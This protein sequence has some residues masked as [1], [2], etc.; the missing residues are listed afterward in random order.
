MRPALRALAAL[1]TATLIALGTIAGPVAAATTTLVSD[2]QA[3]DAAPSTAKIVIIV[4]PTHG[5]TSSFRSDADAAYVEALTW[6]SNVTKIYSPNALWTTVKAAVAGANIVVYLGHGNGWPS[7]YTYDPNYTTKDGF[8]LNDPNNRRDDVVK[9]YGE[10][11]IDDLALAPGAVIILNHSCYSSGSSEPGNPEPTLSVAKQ[12]VDNFGSAF[13]KAGAAA[14]IAA[15]KGSAAN[16]IH[17]LFTQPGTVFDAWRGTSGYK[18]HE[19][20]YPSVRR[21]GNTFILDPDTAGGGGYNHSI[22]GNPQALTSN[23]VGQMATDGDPDSIQVP[24]AAEAA[25]GGATLREHSDPWSDPVAHVNQGTHLRVV[26]EPWSGWDGG[27]GG[28]GPFEV[29][30]ADGST[31]GWVDSEELIPRDSMAP[32]IWAITGGTVFSPNGDGLEDTFPLSVQLSESATWTIKIQSGPT[33]L[34]STS[35]QGN[36]AGLT[37]DGTNGSGQAFPNGDYTWRIEA[38]DQWANAFDY[39]A[40]VTIDRIKPVTRIAGADRYATAAAISSVSYNPGVPVVYIATGSGYADA[41][42]GAP[43]A[44]RDRGPLLLVPGTSIPASVAAELTRLAPARIVVLGGSGA[45][46][47]AVQ[48]ALDAYTTGP[49]TRIAGA[50]RYATAAAI[51]SVSYN[52]GVQVAYIATGTGFADALAGAPVAGRDAGPLL[53][54]PGTSIPASVAAELSRLA[55]GRIV[56]LGGSGAVSADVQAALDAYTPGSVTRISGPDRYATAAAISAASYNP[57]VQVA[58]IATGGGFADALAGAPVAGRDGGPLLLVPGTS[59]PASVAAELS[60]LTPGKI[61]VLGGTGAVS[62]AVGTSLKYYQA[63]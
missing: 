13:I 57:G 9:Y 58:Y 43:V 31:T 2:A 35:G 44:G 30:T 33:V 55:P 63:Q 10:P 54:V 51:S 22:V 25:P 24:G 8:G 26:D 52:P 32:G 39:E 36:V 14:V 56:V 4:G 49:V 23:V 6:T 45:V 15:Y 21:P 18:N 19:M 37:W 53:L 46:S 42:A 27:G 17:S 60:R 1:L 20:A 12:R 34:R 59:I 62:S 16:Y 50:D 29:T 11:S 3:P 48:T 40:A 47:A 7:P 5:L 28:S 61:V 38:A 41:L